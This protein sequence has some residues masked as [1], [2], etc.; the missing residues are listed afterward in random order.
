MKSNQSEPGKKK[1]SFRRDPQLG[2]LVGQFPEWVTSNDEIR[3]VCLFRQEEY[4]PP[5]LC[6]RSWLSRAHLAA[7]ALWLWIQWSSMDWPQSS[8]FPHMVL[9]TR[10]TLHPSFSNSRMKSTQRE[11]WIMAL[12]MG[13]WSISVSWLVSYVSSRTCYVA[14][15]VIDPNWCKTS[16]AMGLRSI[17]TEILHTLSVLVDGREIKRTSV[18]GCTSLGKSG[19][20]LA[21]WVWII[22]LEVARPSLCDI[23]RY[24]LSIVRAILQT[25][26]EPYLRDLEVRTSVGTTTIIWEYHERTL[27]S[28]LI[29]AKW[30]RTWRWT[31]CPFCGCVY[32][33][34]F[35]STL[36]AGIR[37]MRI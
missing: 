30:Y 25:T 5:C 29:L 32:A 36:Q 9:R 10:W 12:Y 14:C 15:T 21:S 26:T 28:P 7:V 35:L 24:R 13:S 37:R 17:R 1:H 31:Q 11:A 22:G 8:S 20:F 27:A 6:W 33:R 3:L 2:R 16:L 4:T 19:S 34:A 18:S 23:S